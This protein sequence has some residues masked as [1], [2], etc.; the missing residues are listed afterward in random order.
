MMR[1]LFDQLLALLGILI[2]L[3]FFILISVWI[4][5]DS[6]G[7][8]FYIQQRMGLNGKPFGLIKFRTMRPDSDLKGKLTVGDRDPR[9]TN[10]GYFLRKYKLD[11]LPQLFNVL[12]G[13]MRFV[14]PRPEVEE[15]VDLYT[16]E[17]KKVLTVK[18]GITDYASLKYF[19][20]SELLAKSH[21]PRQ[22]YIEEI[23]PEKIRINLEYIER[24]SFSEDLKIIFKTIGR[25]FS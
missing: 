10:A 19:K 18:P 8:A 24:K 12:N 4:I 9:I 20:E 7:G 21:N 14:G 22:T 23:M 25:I 5:L 6:K 15:Y 2:L 3:P 11:E 1:D 13:T 17:Q 16:S